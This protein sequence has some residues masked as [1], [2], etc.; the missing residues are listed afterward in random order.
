MLKD[1]YDERMKQLRT[2]CEDEGLAEQDVTV[3]MK[4]AYQGPKAARPRT[5]D[6]KDRV[7]AALKELDLVY[8]LIQ[9]PESTFLNPVFVLF[10]VGPTWAI[11]EFYEAIGDY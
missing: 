7:E 6:M 8:T 9:D 5:M 2:M 11:F 10:L 3:T 1:N 4:F